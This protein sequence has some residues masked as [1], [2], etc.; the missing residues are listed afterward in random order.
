MRVHTQDLVKKFPKVVAV[1]RVNLDVAEGEIF[2]LLGPNGA[3]KT[4]CIAMI[5]GLV[6]PSSGRIEVGGKD[7]QRDAFEVKKHLGVV[8]QELAIY[9]DLSARANLRFF[10]A[11]YGLRGSRLKAAV[12]EALEFTGLTEAADKLPRTFSGGMKRRLNIACGIAHGP[13]LV[14]LDEPTVGID[15]QS[16]H[17][18]LEAVRT[19]NRR[20]ATVIYT[21]H[22]MEEAQALCD[23]ISILDHGKVLASGT[24]AEL[25]A[26]VDDGHRVL[27]TIRADASVDIDGLKSIQGVRSV[28][29]NAGEIRI[30]NDRGIDN[31]APIATWFA[32]AGVSLKS[33]EMDAPDLERVFL[34]LTGRSLRD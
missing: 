21:T 34:S 12:D 19:L 4:T 28:V 32:A 26:M 17:H 5:V 13:S 2:G 14:V 9:D 10:A 11:L 24:T 8:P 30:E 33:V 27:A 29:R 7:A 3:G 20:G 22:Y 1:D 6:K 16:R 15:P 31:L 25:A 23:R 18:I